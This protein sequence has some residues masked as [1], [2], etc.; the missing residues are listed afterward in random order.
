MAGGTALT[1]VVLELFSPSDV[2][3]PFIYFE[4]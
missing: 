1:L 3:I 2:A 4:F